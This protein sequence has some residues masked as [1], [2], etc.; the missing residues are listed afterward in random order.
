MVGLSL[1]KVALSLRK[2]TLSF[3]APTTAFSMAGDMRRDLLLMPTQEGLTAVTDKGISVKCIEKRRILMADAKAYAVWLIATDECPMYH[4]LPSPHLLA[5]REAVLPLTSMPAVVTGMVVLEGRMVV[6][7]ARDRNARDGNGVRRMRG[8]HVF[9]LMLYAGTQ[10]HTLSLPLS[11]VRIDSQETTPER[12]IHSGLLSCSFSLCLSL[13]CHS[14]C[15]SFFE[16]LSLSLSLYVTL[17]VSLSL[18]LFLCVSPF[19][20]LSLCL[21]VCVSLFASLSLRHS[22]CLSFFVS[23]SLFLSL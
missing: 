15:L 4:L 16:S 17:F 12:C 11:F 8:S 1:R 7:L 5:V 3:P 22:L 23:L 18:R 19:E 21:S 2:V 6:M 10:M 20:S 14:L 9:M 13:C